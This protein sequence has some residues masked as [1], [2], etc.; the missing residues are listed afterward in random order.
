MLLCGT[1]EPAHRCQGRDSSGRPVRVRVPKRGAG[2]ESR[3]VVRKVLQRDWSE[4]ATSFSFNEWSTGN[5]R[6][7]LDKA[8]SWSIPKLYVWDAYKRGKGNGG[9]AGV[10][11]KP[12]EEFERA[13]A[14]IL[15]NLW[16]GCRLA[17]TSL[18]R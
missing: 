2:A 9:A 16:T 11:D 4:G 1:W 17:V 10:D 15:Y 13:L 6:S 12:I 8:R 18:R 7:P 5:G 3:V 14:T